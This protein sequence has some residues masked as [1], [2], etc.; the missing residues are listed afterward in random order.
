[1]I[2][3]NRLTKLVP[4]NALSDANLE[5]L[6]KRLNV[7]TFKSGE[8]IC[9]EG[10]TDPETI[11]LLKG[12]V[13]LTSS[14]TT[15]ARH[16]DAGS[17]QALY[18]VVDMPPRPY[19]VTA[20]DEVEIVRIGNYKLDRAVMLDEVTTT[21]TQVT[22]G[23]KEALGGNT[24]WLTELMQGE[25]FSKLPAEKL[26]AMLM[27]LEALP[28][29]SGDVIIRQN[30]PGNYYFIVREGRFN[31]SMK[32]SQGKVGI[33]NELE[34]GSVFGEESL[35]SGK[36]RNASVVAM[37]DGS[38]LRLPK[39][40]FDALLKKPLLTYVTANEAAALVKTGTHLLDVRSSNEFSKGALKGSTNIPVYQLR[41]NLS[42]LDMQARYIICCQT[43]NQS[44]VAAFLLGQRGYDVSVLKGGLR[45]IKT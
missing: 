29:K 14:A 43:G 40:D 3:T 26:A 20:M 35:I 38:L 10:D 45:N 21:I 15:M 25:I 33:L 27:K 31:V 28:V 24:E 41:E 30:D 18:A 36:N 2:E 12:R 13:E 8:I 7:E 19:T 22:G 4:L 17:D 16:L 32:D 39:A 42:K 34:T 1:M 9:R 6:A 11:F 23:N 5:R 44:E 37:T